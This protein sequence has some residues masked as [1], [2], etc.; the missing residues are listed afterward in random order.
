VIAR[1]NQAALATLKN[2]QTVRRLNDLG[3]ELVGST[4]QELT[5][6][7][8]QQLAYYAPIVRASGARIE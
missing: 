4:P 2:A 5:R 1:L 3:A 6:F 7:L 8:D